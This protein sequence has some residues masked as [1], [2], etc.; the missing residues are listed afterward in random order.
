M[1]ALASSELN[2]YAADNQGS[3]IVLEKSGLSEVE[4][5]QSHSKTY[6]HSLFIDDHYLY[7]GSIWT[8]CTIGV[9]DLKTLDN[10]ATL[11]GPLGTIFCLISDETHLFSGAGDS[12]VVIWS[13]KDWSELGSVSGQRHF[14]L[15]LTVDKDHIYAGGIDD[16]TNVFKRDD[17]EQVASLEGHNSNVLALAVDDN[18][19]YSGSGEIWWGGPGSPRP[20]KFESSIRVWDKNDWSCVSVL[21][22]H[23]DNVNSIALDHTFVYSI[24]DDATLRVYSKSDWTEVLCVKVPVMR[25]DSIT[26]DDDAV[27]IACSDGSIRQLMKSQIED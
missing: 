18:Y 12:R 9:Y 8:D 13:K 22:D 21:N 24:S 7:G 27:Y 26:L 2:L 1:T 3:I 10:V 11:D 17:L 23:T 20:P 16:C 6:L 25:I 4:T 5:Y 19:L 15:S 14:V